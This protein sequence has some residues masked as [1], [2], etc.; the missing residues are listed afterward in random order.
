MGIFY[1]S[2]SQIGE[3]LLLRSNRRKG[4][5]KTFLSISRSSKVREIACKHERKVKEHRQERYVNGY[6]QYVQVHGMPIYTVYRIY[7]IYIYA[8]RRFDI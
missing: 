8:Q 7:T 1:A 5:S 6:T 2:W 4:E 3:H